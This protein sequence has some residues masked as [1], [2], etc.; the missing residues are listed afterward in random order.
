MKR[1]PILSLW[2]L[3]RVA[4]APYDSSGSLIS[5]SLEGSTD[6]DISYHVLLLGDAGFIEVG[7][8]DLG[9]PRPIRMKWKGHEYLES[10]GDNALDDIGTVVTE[11]SENSG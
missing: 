3:G 10:L 7:K 8:D 5:L 1:D 4:E 2:I 11:V 6:D 9:R